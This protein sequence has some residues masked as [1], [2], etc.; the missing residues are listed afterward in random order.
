MATLWTTKESEFESREAQEFS[1][2]HVAQ[3]GFEVYPN[4]YPMGTQGFF[5]RGK[6]AVAWSV[7]GTIGV[8]NYATQ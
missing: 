3:T 1:L 7:A 8:K 6:A 2:L 4:S 5:S